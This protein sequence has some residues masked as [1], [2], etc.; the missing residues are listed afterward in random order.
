MAVASGAH[1]ARFLLHMPHAFSLALFQA[2]SSSLDTSHVSRSMQ[3]SSKKANRDIP[4]NNALKIELNKK[5]KWVA[6]QTYLQR[7]PGK[8]KRKKKADTKRDSSTIFDGG[9]VRR[10]MKKI[11]LLIQKKG[12]TAAFSYQSCYCR[13]PSFPFAFLSVS[14]ERRTIR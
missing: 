11:L 1:L 7:H 8:K 12:S 13:A 2:F 5:N 10:F 14:K 9:S 3:P 6:Q 4:I